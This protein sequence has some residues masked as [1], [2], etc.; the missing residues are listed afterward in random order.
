MGEIFDT[1]PTITNH[2]EDYTHTVS[3]D[4]PENPY[5]ETYAKYELAG[6]R[7]QEMLR[8]E[9]IT[10]SDGDLVMYLDLAWMAIAKYLWAEYDDSEMI[11]ICSFAIA[12]LA[13]IYYHNEQ[14]KRGIIRGEA[15]VTQMSQGSRSVT[16]GSK[17]IELDTFGLTADV[18]AALPVRKL[19]VL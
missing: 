11:K 5:A 12:Q 4:P 9:N 15:P 1:L 6:M 8:E 7:F 18:K 3:L 13:F 2:P 19:R 14:I 17:K 10:I 16:Y